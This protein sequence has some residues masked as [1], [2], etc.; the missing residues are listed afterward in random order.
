[1]R[2]PDKFRGL[3]YLKPWLWLHVVN[4]LSIF[5]SCRILQ[6]FDPLFGKWYMLSYLIALP[7]LVLV[8]ILMAIKFIGSLRLHTLENLTDDEK[9]RFY[10][11]EAYDKNNNPANH[12]LPWN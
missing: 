7:V 2:K 5:G 6:I 12:S 1:M 11:P 4:V 10:F 8:S 9:K 3:N